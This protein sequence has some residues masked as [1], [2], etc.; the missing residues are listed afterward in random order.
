MVLAGVQIL[1]GSF[2][3]VVFSSGFSDW[4]RSASAMLACGLAGALPATVFA[5]IP[6]HARRPDQVSVCNGIIMQ[7]GSLGSFAGPPAIAMAVTHL[8]VGCGAMAY[9]SFGACWLVCS[10][11]LAGRGAANRIKRQFADMMD[12]IG[13]QTKVTL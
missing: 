2:G 10:R 3:W 12:C 8:G 11:Y 1:I 13:V 6:F 5:G 4:G 7:C 9:T